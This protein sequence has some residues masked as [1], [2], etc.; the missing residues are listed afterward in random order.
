MSVLIPTK[1]RAADLAL[2]IESVLG[3]TTLPDELLIVDQSRDEAAESRT[4]A[5][6]ALGTPARL[7][8]VRR[9]ELSGLAAARNCAMDRACGEIWLFLDDDVVLEPDF[10]AQLLAAY[11]A[12]PEATG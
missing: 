9:P 8:Y 2:T 1:D 3:Q 4:R 6:W 12:H 5:R 10:L 7:V 11:R